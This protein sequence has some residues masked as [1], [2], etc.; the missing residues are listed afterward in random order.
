MAQAERTAAESTE[1]KRSGDEIISAGSATAE[2]AT[3]KSS[4]RDSTAER[5]LKLKAFHIV[6]I[7]YHMQLDLYLLSL[8]LTCVLMLAKS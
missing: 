5:S 2:F 4:V 6:I 1:D 3:E 8:I 7:S